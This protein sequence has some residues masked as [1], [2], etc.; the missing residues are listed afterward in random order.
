MTDSKSTLA[1]QGGTKA[2]PQMS[3][4]PQ[5]KIGIEEFMSIAERFGFTAEALE[6]LRA[7]VSEAD[8]GPVPTWPNMLQLPAANQGRGL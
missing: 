8:L 1:L 4:N 7:A 2:F 3:G 6:R 5:P